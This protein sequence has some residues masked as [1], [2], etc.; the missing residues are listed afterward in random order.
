[1]LSYL[2]QFVLIQRILNYITFDSN[3]SLDFDQFTGS[4][5]F[6]NSGYTK[7]ATIN[8]SGEFENVP[9]VFLTQEWIDFTT[10]QTQIELQ[11]ISI[12][13]TQFSMKVYC[14]YNRM[15][16]SMI[17][18]FAIDDQ[19]IEVINNFNMVNP[20][21]K[22][23]QIKNP[24]AQTGFVVL[25]SIH[26]T[27]AID[28]LLSISQITMHSVTVSITKVAGKFTNLKQIGYQ[29]IVG[30]EEAFIN[31]G[32][33]TV[34]GAFSSDILAIQPNRW[35]AIALQGFN[36]PNSRNIRIKAVFTNTVSTLS[37]TW[38]TWYETETPNSH[39]QIW[40][41]YQFTKSY[42][43]LECFSIR[44]SRK[45]VMDLT[46]LPTFSLEFVSLNQI[47][48]TI[49]N[50]NYLVDK[51]ISPLLMAIQIKCLSGKKIQAKFN[52]CNSCSI[53]KF[54]TFQY[55][56]LNQM[57]YVGF[58]P[59][60]NQAFKQYNELKINIYSSSLEITQII[61]DQKVTEQSIVDIQ[62][63]NQ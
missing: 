21:D 7:T 10:A 41:A 18:W 20:D 32:L 4:G 22:T 33:K 45:F 31:L 39:S 12:S 15:T 28:F 40:I 37:Y 60:F 59:R 16:T 63:L 56:C 14:G 27:G 61:Y 44:I 36:Y 43:A 1:M 57:N 49:G 25:T 23:F 24:N 3:L 62:I 38:G 55:N 46:Y 26:Y 13:K 2:I 58:F 50:F 54:H 35:F 5:F 17:K 11:I 48:T 47:Y 42:K 29:V 52:K 34:M 9:Q 53:Q 30:V 51:S 19:R 6:C 8:F